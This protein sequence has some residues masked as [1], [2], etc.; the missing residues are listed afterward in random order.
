[1]GRHTPGFELGRF[2]LSHND[3]EHVEIEGG[4]KG[5]R[6]TNEAIE[7]RVELLHQEVAGWTGAVGIQL[8]DRQF[9]AIGDEAFIPKS[10]IRNGGI[11]GW[12][13]L[14]TGT[15]AMNWD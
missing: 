5:T 2:R 15:G 12:E 6:F 11:F 10:D 4:E 3:Y 8:E 14:I 7:G 1:M 13:K 9:A